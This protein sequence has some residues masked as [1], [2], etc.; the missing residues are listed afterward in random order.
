MKLKKILAAIDGSEASFMALDFALSLAK[1]YSASLTILTV[2]EPLNPT[3]SPTIPPSVVEP[4]LNEVRA[5]YEGIL[6]KAMQRVTEGNKRPDVNTVL[7]HGRAWEKIV[8]ECRDGGYDLLVMGSRGLGG[9]KGFIL[10]SVS[11]RAVE[12]APCPVLIVKSAA[13]QGPQAA[14]ESA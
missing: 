14:H 5:Y 7:L 2:V 6:E 3:P 11:K 12:E 9:I 1:K 4:Y 8:G 10:G 13:E